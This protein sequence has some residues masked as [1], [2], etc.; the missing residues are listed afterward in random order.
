MDFLWRGGGNLL[1][2]YYMDPKCF[3]PDFRVCT[4]HVAYYIIFVHPCWFY[5]NLWV[6]SYCRSVFLYFLTKLII[7][8]FTWHKCCK[9]NEMHN[10]APP[11]FIILLSIIRTQ[12]ITNVVFI[13]RSTEDVLNISTSCLKPYFST[14]SF[15]GLF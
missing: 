15:S 6:G 7:W 5:R 4:M 8:I 14:F 10:F 9:S 2:F 3:I 13:E 1:S 12:Y 11:N